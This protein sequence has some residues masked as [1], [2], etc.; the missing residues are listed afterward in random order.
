[1]I[2]IGQFTDHSQYIWFVETIVTAYTKWI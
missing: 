1:M 2:V